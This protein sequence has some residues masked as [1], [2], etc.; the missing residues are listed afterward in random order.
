[1][2]ENL[3]K[4]VCPSRSLFVGLGGIGA[5][6]TGRLTRKCSNTDTTNIRFVVMDTNVNDLRKLIAETNIDIKTIQTSST[7]TVGSYLNY[8]IEASRDWF[9]KNSIL[10]NKT[11]SEGAGQVRAISRLALNATIRQGKIKP[12]YTA[13]DE[14][15]AKDGREF[16]QALRVYIIASAT[17]GTG[18]G[19][20]LAVALLIRRYMSQVYPES[21][22]MIRGLMVLPGVLDTVISSEKER[23][24][25]RRNGYATIKEVNAFMMLGSKFFDVDR[26]LARYRDLC[27]EVPVQ[28]GEKV[29]LNELPFDFC[30]LLD[31]LDLNQGNMKTLDQYKDYAAQSLFEQNIGP[32]QGDSFSVEDN[33]VKEAANKEMR[34]R[35]RFGGIGAAVIQYPY[36]S[37]ADYIALNWAVEQITGRSA[38]TADTED[39][40]GGWLQYDKEFFR[41]MREYRKNGSS[42]EAAPDR[43]DVYLNKLKQSETK[44]SANLR[45]RYLGG[46]DLSEV[47]DKLKKLISDYFIALDTVLKERLN[48]IP[49]YV[50]KYNEVKGLRSGSLFSGNEDAKGSAADWFRRADQYEELARKVS[51]SIGQSAGNAIFWDE[52]MRL[53]A[54]SPNYSIEHILK[55]E[56]GAM[57]PNAMR[58]VLYTLRT[59]FQK[60]IAMYTENT[61]KATAA[62]NKYSATSQDAQFVPPLSA[63]KGEDG[64]YTRQNVL[65]DEARYPGAARKEKK[66]IN[67][68]YD[69][70]DQWGKS[71]VTA[72]DSMAQNNVFTAAYRLGL[73]YVNGLIAAF[74]KFY[75][76]F[77]DKAKN[78]YVKIEDIEKE[79]EYSNGDSF[80]R[81]CATRQILHEIVARCS[82]NVDE[83]LPEDLN[84]KIYNAM[85]RNIILEREMENDPG[86]VDKRVDVFDQEII[87]YFKKSVRENC[88]DI[89][90]RNILE[91]IQWECELTELIK[92]KQNYERN[93]DPNEDKPKTVAVD[94]QTVSAYITK[95]IDEGRILASPGISTALFDEPRIVSASSYNEELKL[96]RTI[97]VGDYITTGGTASK[98][99]SKYELHFFEALYNVTPDKLAR[100]SAPKKSETGL[101]EAG[102]YFDAYQEYMKGVGPDSTKSMV[103]SPHIDKRWDTIAVMPEL[104]IDY[105]NQSIRRIHLAFFYGL[106]Y[107]LIQRR[108]ITSYDP[109]KVYY[110]LDRGDGDFADLVVSNGTPCDEFFEVLNSLY[111]DRSAVEDILAVAEKYRMKDSEKHTDYDRTFFAR[112]IAKLHVPYSDEPLNAEK[113]LD[114]VF[115]I[116]LLYNKS[117]PNSERDDAE[118]MLMIE[119]I[120][121]AFTTE[122]DTFD[123]EKDK[124]SHLQQIMF[125]QLKLLEKRYNEDLSRF[126][127]PTSISNDYDDNEVVRWIKRMLKE[128]AERDNTEEVF[129][130]SRDES[131]PGAD[132]AEIDDSENE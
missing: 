5:D 20:A 66:K 59:E 18:S 94:K 79:L 7:Q 44:L 12:L 93:P 58:A 122:P 1:M 84:S 87:Q 25:I 81:V 23:T 38:D 104:D 24:S 63:K 52:E 73:D 65:D 85:K 126:L 22:C 69:D 97:K 129:E 106:V 75:D 118:L 102:I 55:A 31:R 2:A 16:K 89:I 29:A 112:Q 127:Q 32:M 131:A 21:N 68:V 109:N 53:T 124:S 26:N 54:S 61:R 77:N 100:F 34:G 30:F 3:E 40:P 8:D 120:I 88:K 123:R 10:Y 90:D 98:S 121:E 101:S 125:N 50:A 76:K 86:V 96:S 57:H 19:I 99:V 80:M 78:L 107:E 74:H 47:N 36:E 56:E 70:I 130:E 4:N 95:R 33:I 6:I 48:S 39:N 113:T 37:I 83:V 28:D 41:Q 132:A 43:G 35:N 117:V 110:Q 64:V 49:D 27:V 67:A 91:A 92:A 111:R 17:G 51:S 71:Y 108:Q 105:M 116:P 9:P 82:Q 13:I 14:L 42:R 114:S 60:K 72:I 119:S 11:V 115:A 45:R 46:N 15:F 62:I 128:L 103:I